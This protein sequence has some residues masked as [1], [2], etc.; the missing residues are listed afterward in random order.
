VVAARESK[1]SLHLWPRSRSALTHACIG[2]S[3]C[4][5][6]NPDTGPS[7]QRRRPS[8]AKLAR[9][10]VGR[11][12]GRH[13][14]QVPAARRQKPR[15][16]TTLVS[17]SRSTPVTRNE[18]CMEPGMLQP[19]VSWWPCAVAASM[20]RSLT[21]CW[22][23]NG[24]TSPRWVWL[25]PW[26]LSLRMIPG[27]VKEQLRQP[28]CYLFVVLGLAGHVLKQLL[29]DASEELPRFSTTPLIKPPE[30]TSVSDSESCCP[31]RSAQSAFSAT[32]S[33]AHHGGRE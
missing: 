32:S 12:P 23:P 17:G 9:R 20:M 14:G 22:R 26:S 16:S 10:A 21:S 30:T 1:P 19:R 6:C 18:V 3:L 24:I 15:P 4:I 28:F 7:S 25:A 5:T 13:P 8:T 31:V 33:R 29:G 27:L 2:W 11:L